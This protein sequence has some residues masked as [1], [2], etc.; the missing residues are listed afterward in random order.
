MK[1]RRINL[2]IDGTNLFAGQNEIFGPD[3]FLPFGHLMKQINKFFKIDKIFFYASYMSV[4]PNKRFKLKYLL[5]SEAE[6]YRQVRKYPNLTFFKG[7]RSLTSGK[8]K[9]VDVHLASD[10]IK[11]G[12]LGHYDEVIIMTGDADLIYPI[13]IAKE[14]K[15]KTYAIFLPNRFSLELAYKV[16]QG[17]IL[18]YGKLFDNKQEKRNK[19]FPKTLK[20][21][22]IKKP[23]M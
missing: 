16:N 9:G 23:R 11:D 4:F 6:F 19:K 1:K 14:L 7:H 5:A 22:E 3:K 12:F 8:E 15:F 20:I 17:I 10:I 13:E 18:N 21:V 2:Y